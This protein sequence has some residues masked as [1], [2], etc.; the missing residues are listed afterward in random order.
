L[1]KGDDDDDDDDD[2]D[3][4]NNNTFT[5]V[6]VHVVKTCEVRSLSL[7]GSECKMS[8]YG[9][10]IPVNKNPAHN[11]CKNKRSLLVAVR[12][13]YLE[14]MLRIITVIHFCVKYMWEQHQKIEIV[15]VKK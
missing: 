11:A 8:H 6:S 2:D 13:V 3:N 9:R 5:A 15:C 7:D 4:N 12:E 10:F 14:I 1:H